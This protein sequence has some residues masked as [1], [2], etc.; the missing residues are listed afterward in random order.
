MVPP[1]GKFLNPFQGFWQNAEKVKGWKDE[2]SKLTGLKDEVKVYFDNRLVPHVFTKNDEDLY[3]MQGYITARYRLW[4]MEMQTANAAGRLSEIIGD[5]TLELDRLQR[6][7]GLG[8]GAEEAQKFI[9]QD[10][11]SKKLIT[12]Y[13]NGVNAY[14]KMLKPKDYPV[15]YKLLDY[16]PEEW[17]PIK[18]GLLL[19]G[20]IWAL[21]TIVGVP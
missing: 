17:K 8:Y 16:A 5:K 2:E 6:R 12:A 1:C 3:F 13:C 9:D 20:A 7:I 10:P 21:W 14:I 4:Q 11:E 15:E 18:V 19:L